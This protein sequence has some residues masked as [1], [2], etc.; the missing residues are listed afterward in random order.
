M[1]AT[2]ETFCFCTLAL[3]PKYRL[4][5]QQLAENLEQFAP[6]IQL[7][8]LT[9]E[10]KD[11]ANNRNVLAFQHQQQGILHCYHDKRFPI[12]RALDQF[13]A[14]I[15]IDADTK[16]TAAISPQLIWQGGLTARHQENLVEHVSQYNPERL[17]A[18]EKVAAKLDINPKDVTYVGE[19]LFVVRK[20]QGKEREFLKY[21]GMI[22]RYLELQNVHAGSGIA[23]GLAAFKAGFPIIHDQQI[24]EIDNARKHIDASYQKKGRTR[25]EKISRRMGY[26]YRLN[27]TRLLAL[28]NF[29]FYYL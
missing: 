25:W 17:S 19:S 10:P 8:V 13:D 21:W 1:S 2:P 22:G 4:L 27:K 5:T 29:S 18:V 24:D 14:A 23:I 11:F 7:V 9:D 12:E 3:R 15:L 6:G 26:H 28:T 16:I 20:N